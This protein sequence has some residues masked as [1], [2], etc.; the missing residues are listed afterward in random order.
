MKKFIG[1]LFRPTSQS[2]RRRLSVLVAL[3]GVFTGLNIAPLFEAS[4][5][6][7]GSMSV[8]GANEHSHSITNVVGP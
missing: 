1:A 8:S 2:G 6:G 7:S 3:I 5:S 4:V